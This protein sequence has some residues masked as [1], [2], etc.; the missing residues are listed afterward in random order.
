MIKKETIIINEIRHGYIMCEQDKKAPVILYLHGGPGSPEYPIFQSQL[1]SSY[2]C[3]FNVC[4]YDHRGCGLSFNKK[5]E[6]SLDLLI[7]DI[8]DITKYLIEKYD[9]K[10]IILVAHSFGTYLGIK[11]VQSHPEYYSAYVG[12]SQITNVRESEK[13]IYNDLLQ[14]CKEKKDYKGRKLLKKNKRSSSKLSNH[15]MQNVKGR[16]LKRYQL[17]L[18]R[19]PLPTYFMIQKL[20]SFPQY[21]FKNKLE[22]CK[23][24]IHSS[25]LLFSMTK[26]INLF[27]NSCDFKVPIYFIHGIY[28]YQVSLPLG[29]EYFGQLDSPKKELIIFEESAHFPNFEEPDK[30]NEILNSLFSVEQV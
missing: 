13:R 30:F 12:I 19:E 28:D 7:E 9:K 25:R 1:N 11:A 18:T 29:K 4:Y 3:E 23:G 5:S 22:Y 20:F 16:L 6:L 14:V 24:L 26:D 17:G 15:Y 27:Q 2:L 10:K 8:L 21:S